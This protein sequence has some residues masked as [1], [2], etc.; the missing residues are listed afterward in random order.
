MTF[1]LLLALW[2]NPAALNPPPGEHLAFQVHATG[3]QIYTCHNGA[4]TLKAPDAKLFDSSGKQ[5]GKHFAGPTWESI[6]GSQVKGKLAASAPSPDPD[7]IP[8]LL[9]TAADHQG[10]GVMTPVTS[11]QRIHTK[12]GK[13]P[14]AACESEGSETRSSY[15]ADYL[16]YSR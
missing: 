15:E 10:S 13:A 12:S 2:Q 7:S 16:F 9:V 5:V 14:K 1:V 6:D 4:W 8:W 3:D 11:I